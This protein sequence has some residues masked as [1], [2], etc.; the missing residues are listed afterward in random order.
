MRGAAGHRAEDARS[1]PPCALS[2]SGDSI[3]SGFRPRRAS[4]RVARRV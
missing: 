2:A 4:P 1:G 3:L